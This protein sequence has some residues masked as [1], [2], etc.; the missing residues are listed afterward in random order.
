MNPDTFYLI[1]SSAERINHSVVNSSLKK[2]EQCFLRNVDIDQVDLKS[3][4]IKLQY[5]AYNCYL[6]L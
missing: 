2:D 6:I 1:I 4:E 5:D 3:S